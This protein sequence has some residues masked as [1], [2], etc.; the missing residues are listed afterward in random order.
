MLFTE[1]RAQLR[2]SDLAQRCSKRA[3]RCEVSL[4][5]QRSLAWSQDAQN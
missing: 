1:P 2:L 3:T 4:S 5:Q